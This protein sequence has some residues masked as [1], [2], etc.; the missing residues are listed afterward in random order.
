MSQRRVLRPEEAQELY[1]ALLDD[2]TEPPLVGAQDAA[3]SQ[4]ARSALEQEVD[5]LRRRIR[6][7]ETGLAIA[8]A[9]RRRL[10]LEATLVKNIEAAERR[11][12]Q[13][14]D[15]LDV[16][17][18]PL[19]MAER[20]LEKERARLD[21]FRAATDTSRAVPIEEMDVALALVHVS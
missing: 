17:P 9:E 13:L 18:F 3:D 5:R 4:A 8:R 11:L 7:T 15:R 12:R 21:E 20:T 1:R 14:R 2:A 6:D 16:H 10:T 19:R